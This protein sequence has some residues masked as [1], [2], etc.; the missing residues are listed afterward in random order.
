MGFFDKPPRPP[1]VADNLKSNAVQA[2]CTKITQETTEWAPGS[3]S[4][5][6]TFKT[7][8]ATIGTPV[9]CSTDVLVKL[10]TPYSKFLIVS[11]TAASIS[12]SIYFHLE[13]V[14]KQYASGVNAITPDGNE[15]WLSLLTSGRVVALKFDKPINEFYLDFDFAAGTSYAFTLLCYNNDFDFRPDFTINNFLAT[16]NSKDVTIGININA[17]NQI[18]VTN[19]DTLV[20]A[21]NSARSAV[22]ITNLGT[23]IV[24]LGNAGLTALTG[25]GLFPGASVTIPVVSA[26]HGIVANST[27]KVSYLEIQ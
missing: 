4:N 16:I 26:V 21:A 2:A 9:I 10:T 5:N 24:F 20:I 1:S 13:K 27:A 7:V 23:Q 17:T 6:V 15:A 18:T 22:L 11:V 12:N 19:V 8:K 14:S 25:H 3:G